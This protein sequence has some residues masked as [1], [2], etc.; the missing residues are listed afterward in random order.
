MTAASTLG[1]SQ[2]ERH[3]TTDTPN[4]VG[5]SSTPHLQ[6]LFQHTRQPATN[7]VPA[8]TSSAPCPTQS[9]VLC[10]HLHARAPTRDHRVILALLVGTSETPLVISLTRQQHH[11]WSFFQH[12]LYQSLIQPISFTIIRLVRPLSLGIFTTSFTWEHDRPANP[13]DEADIA[14]HFNTRTT[15]PNPVV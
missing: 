2:N 7:W 9:Q 6:L 14:A 12:T 15:R 4:T 1:T 11:H 10:R 8:A 13:P 3:D 5:T